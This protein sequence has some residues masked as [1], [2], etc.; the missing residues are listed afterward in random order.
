MREPILSV[1]LGGTYVLTHDSVGLD[2]DRPTHRPI[3]H[4]TTGSSRPVA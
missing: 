1:D 3:E 4:P 2:G